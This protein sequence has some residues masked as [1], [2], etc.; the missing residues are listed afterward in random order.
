MLEVV[1]VV[2]QALLFLYIVNIF[3]TWELKTPFFH[4]LVVNPSQMQEVGNL[5][6]KNGHL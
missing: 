1:L 6:K 3:P 5:S 4:S 2:L